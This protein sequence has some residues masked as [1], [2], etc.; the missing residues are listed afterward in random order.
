LNINSRLVMT[1]FEFA[2]AARIVFGRGKLAEVPGLVREFGSRALIVT[3][4]DT[5]RAD[6]LRQSLTE[7]GIES[8]VVSVPSEPTVDLV[9]V[10]TLAAKTCEFV[11]GFGGGSAIDA[12]KAIAAVATNSGEPLDYLEVVGKGRSLECLPLPFVAVPTTAGTGAEVTSNAVLNSPEHALKASLRS[13]AMLARIALI[14]PDLTLDVPPSVTVSTGLDALTQLIEAYVSCRAN[15]M[16]D[17]FCLEGITRAAASLPRAFTNGKDIEARESMS[18]ASLLSG[19]ALANAGLG[20]VHAF[21]GPLGSL[22][23]APHGALCAAL[24]PFAMRINVST[25]RERAPQREALA[26]YRGVAV[27]L[28]GNE[29]AEPEDAAGWLIQLSR[30][31]NV[32]PLRSFGLSEAQIPRLVQKALKASSMRGNPLVLSEAE[33][34]SLIEEAL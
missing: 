29:L 14:D 15:P 24:L 26:R 32:R 20:V 25:L 13:P 9:R 10:G 34:S 7:A 28:T 2:T 23:H 33:L 3:G 27:L 19:L 21:A 5:T 8:K 1:R 6:G 30:D 16:T 12:A 31:L 4:R 17:L 22:L 11:I 18:W